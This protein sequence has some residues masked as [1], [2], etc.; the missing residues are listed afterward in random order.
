MTYKLYNIGHEG[1]FVTFS[2]TA[3]S[4]RRICNQFTTD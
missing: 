4:I 3:Q 1:Q 2:D